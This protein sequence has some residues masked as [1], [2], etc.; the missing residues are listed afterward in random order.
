MSIWASICL[1]VSSATPTT[2]MID[3]PPMPCPAA[4]LFHPPHA[5]DDGESACGQVQRPEQ[6]IL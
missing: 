3:V 4:C 6:V 1:S 5:E 2:M